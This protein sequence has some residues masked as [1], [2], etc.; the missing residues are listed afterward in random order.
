MKKH[1]TQTHFIHKKDLIQSTTKYNN[2]D[3]DD[4]DDH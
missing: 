1:R 3:D 2:D 4:Y